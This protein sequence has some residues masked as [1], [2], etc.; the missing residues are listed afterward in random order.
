MV[1]PEPFSQDS[2]DDFEVNFD[3]ND[4]YPPLNDYS[5]SHD[6]GEASQEAFSA[7][8]DAS[9]HLPQ[10]QDDESN[11][12]NLLSQFN[13]DSQGESAAVLDDQSHAPEF[14]SEGYDLRNLPDPTLT[15]DNQSQPESPAVQPDRS[16]T[17]DQVGE[18]TSWPG[19]HDQD[20]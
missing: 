12:F 2:V 5:F 6:Q 10:N 11:L 4:V 13:A 7:N 14:A 17:Q 1:A 18:Y 9:A 20:N 19:L 15:Q 16:Q 3:L 8:T